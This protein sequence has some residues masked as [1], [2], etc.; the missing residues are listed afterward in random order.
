LVQICAFFFF[1][2]TNPRAILDKKARALRKKT[3]NGHLYT[4]WD[5]PDQKPLTKLGV[6]FKRPFKLLATQPIVQFIGIYMAFLYGLMYLVLSTFAGLWINSY[7]ETISIGGLNYISTGLGFFAGSRFNAFFQDRVYRRLKARNG[8]VAKPEFRI[9]LMIPGSIL[10]PIG[11]FIYA[12]TSEYTTFWL[13]PNVGVFIVTVGMIICFQSMQVYVV[14]TYSRYAASAVAA[15]V[16][17]RSLAGFGFPLF[18]SQPR[19]DSSHL[20]LQTKG[21]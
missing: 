21:F 3:G 6:A 5:E 9:P 13:W 4:D 8:G 11:I 15:T 7:H 17:L 20:I 2:E 18:V 1:A 12:W 16:V 19:S 14:E 10:V